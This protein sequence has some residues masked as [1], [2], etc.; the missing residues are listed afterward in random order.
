[1]W[2]NLDEQ[3]FW[4]SAAA[5]DQVASNILVRSTG[6]VV[7]RFLGA[8]N[9]SDANGLNRFKEFPL[10]SCEEGGLNCFSVGQ[11]EV[12]IHFMHIYAG[13]G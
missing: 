10:R 9:C 2:W 7:V 4:K 8:Q 12:D 11:N 5:W 1:M 6:C 3:F 13:S